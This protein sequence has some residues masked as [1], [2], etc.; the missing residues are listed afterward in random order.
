MS[1]DTV[2]TIIRTQEGQDHTIQGDVSLG[3]GGVRYSRPLNG[4]EMKRFFIPYSNVCC[5]ESITRPKE[6][7]KSEDAEEEEESSESVEEVE[8]TE[9]DSEE[10]ESE[11]EARKMT[12]FE[13][14]FYDHVEDGEVDELK[15][16]YITEHI[17]EVMVADPLERALELD[18][19]KTTTEAYEERL[20][21][22]RG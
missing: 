12:E 16:K 7:Q 18:D 8:D 17:E 2:Q 1:R 21:E 11:K 14:D 3:R 20:E 15:A 22:L 10:E 6:V 5:V 19:R 4:E 13:E 9:E